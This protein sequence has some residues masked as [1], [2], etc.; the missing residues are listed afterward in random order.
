MFCDCNFWKY[1]LTFN[2]IFSIWQFAGLFGYQG[3]IFSWLVYIVDDVTVIYLIFAIIKSLKDKNLVWNFNVWQRQI[4]KKKPSDMTFFYLLS[5]TLSEALSIA[6]INPT[7]N[8]TSLHQNFNSLWVCPILLPRSLKFQVLY[9]I[10]VALLN[11]SFFLW[12]CKLYFGFH[13]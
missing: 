4:S 12:L 5:L 2:I 13:L 3:S 8:K 10:F 7:K 11:F 1:E 9:V 6:I